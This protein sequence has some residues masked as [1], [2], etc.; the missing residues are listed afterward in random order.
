M[1]PHEELRL[2]MT[3]KG[4]TKAKLA[5]LLGVSQ[6]VVN[7]MLSGKHSMLMCNYV[8]VKQVISMQEG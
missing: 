5:E 1:Q 6:P 4:L 8:R 2:L 7:R 3:K